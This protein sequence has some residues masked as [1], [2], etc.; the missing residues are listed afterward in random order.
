MTRTTK[1]LCTALLTM[2]GLAGSSLPV[3]AD[4]KCDRDIH[5]AEDKLREAIAKHGEHSKQADKRRQ[6]LEEVRRRCGWQDD[7]H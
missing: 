4:E 2:A 6:E 7:H 5:K 3:V 1:V